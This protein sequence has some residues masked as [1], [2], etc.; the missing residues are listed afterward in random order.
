M[1]ENYTVSYPVILN[2]KLFYLMGNYFKQNNFEVCLL[3]DYITNQEDKVSI[4]NVSKNYELP[5]KDFD[6]IALDAQKNLL[7]TIKN[8]QS[9]KDSYIIGFHPKGYMW[10]FRNH[11][12]KRLKDNNI[13]IIIWQDDLHSYPKTRKLPYDQIVFDESLNKMDLLLTPSIHYWKNL[14]HPYLNKSVFYFYCFN[15]NYFDKLP[16]NNYD[17]RINKILLSGANYKGYPIR[18]AL[19][20]YYKSNKNNSQNNLAKYIDYYSHPSYDR[21]K[22]KGKTGLDYYIKLSKYKGAFFGFYEYPLNYPLAKIIEILAC[23]T[24]GFFEDSPVLHEYLGLIKF[25]HFVPLLVNSKN[26]PIFDMNYY[27]KYLN[28]DLGKKIAMDGCQFIRNKF[29]MKNK[30]DELISLLLSHK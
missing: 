26:E 24:L 29:T 17:T 9:Y 23:G 21:S 25:K 15:E 20:T 3:K 10:F 18:Q 5:D 8:D 16:I 12:Y 30:C 6:R 27:L 19:L 28:S 14:N 1:K 7:E 13:K 11:V 4:E 2:F 22:N